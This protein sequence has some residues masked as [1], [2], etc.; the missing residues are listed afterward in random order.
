MSDG[1]RKFRPKS[2]SRKGE[3]ISEP[4]AERPLQRPSAPRSSKS[5]GRRRPRRR[6]AKKRLDPSMA[7]FIVL[8]P[9]TI[10][11]GLIMAFVTGRVEERVEARETARETKELIEKTPEFKEALKNTPV[12]TH[13]T[14]SQ[15]NDIKEMF[16]ITKL[17]AD[18]SRVEMDSLNAEYDEKLSEHEERELL[19]PQDIQDIRERS[20]QRKIIL[21]LKIATRNL[22]KAARRNLD[23]FAREIA[24]STISNKT[25]AQMVKTH[26]KQSAAMAHSMLGVVVQICEHELKMLKFFDAHLDSMKVTDSGGA[27][28]SNSA[29]DAQYSRLK[30]K[31]NSLLVE[32]EAKEKAGQ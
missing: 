20:R 23:R 25:K 32:C 22:L 17:V 30:E 6:V 16:R 3:R 29:V 5:E 15:G 10:V 28:F 2:K 26:R 11:G 27:S 7:V 18:E 31:H 19:I 9:L 8:V 4:I 14:K 12:P 1:T 13:M 24:K 21:E